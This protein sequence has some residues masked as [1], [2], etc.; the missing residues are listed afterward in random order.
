MVRG[1]DGRSLFGDVVQPLQVN[2]EED[3]QQRTD[4][5]PLEEV[6]QHVL[7]FLQ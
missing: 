1:E 3:L 4:G 5:E 2:L 7:R 6:I